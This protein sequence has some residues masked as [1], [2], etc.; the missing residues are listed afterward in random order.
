MPALIQPSFA[1]GEISPHLY[2]RV[3]TAAYYVALALARNVIVHP[4]GGI[5]NRPGT[6]F[7]APCGE[8]TYAPRLIDFQF[9][10]TDTYVLEFGHLY[11]R[12]IRNDG[13]VL[14]A[15]KNITAISAALPGVVTSNAHGFANG[16]EVFLQSIVG[17]T[18]LNGRWFRVANVTANTFTLKDQV[19]GFDISTVG[20][21]AY[22]SGG[23]ASRVY[24]LT[25]PYTSAQIDRLKVVQNAD[26]M[27]I[28]H[29]SHPVN[30]LTRTAHDAWTITP[31]TFGASW[32]LPGGLT[33]TPSPTGAVTYSYT[34]TAI[35]KETGKESL[36]GLISASQ[37]I[38]AA[39]AANP[40][41]FTSA[42]HGNLTGDLVYLDNIA[43]SGPWT[44]LNGRYFTINNA[45]AN[46]YEIIDEDNNL[47]D[48][49]A[50]GAYPG[51]GR[52]RRA[53]VKIT[54]GAATASNTIGWTNINAERYYVYKFDNGQFGFIGETKALSFKDDN[55]QANLARTPPE[56]R[57]FAHEAGKYPQA[58]GYHEQR[59]IF[60][61]SDTA[62]DQ[63]DFSQVGG[64]ENM[65]RS[66]P[67]QAD[68]AFTTK[69]NSRQV[70]E[71]RHFVSLSDL[72]TF[73]DGAEW[74]S[75]A[76]SDS[77]F[78]AESIRQRQQSTWGCSHI[79]PLVVGD[80]VLFI[81]PS[82]SKVR[83]L[84][85]SFQ[86]DGYSG[87]QVNL[88]S[89]HMTEF[90]SF[91]D[92]AL[93]MAPEPR[94]YAP[95][96]DGE[97]L[98][99][100]YEQEQEVIGWSH[101]D[102]D[103][104]YE[105][106]CVLRNSTT[107]ASREN[108]IYYIIKRKINGVTVRYIEKQ[109]SRSI[110]DVRDAYFVD[111]GLSYDAPIAIEG[112]TSANPVVVTATGHGL[113]NGA[114]V[115][116]SGIKWET[117]FDSMFNAV[118]PNHLN[119]VQFLVANATANTFEIT[120]MLGAPIDGSGFSGYIEGGSIR[121]CVSTLTGF[122]HILGKEIVVLADGDVF[123]GITIDTVAGGVGFTLPGGRKAA[124]IHAGLRF[125]SDAQ[126][127]SIESPSG[128]IQGKMA[129]INGVSVRVKDTRGL[130]VGPSFD[131]L[132]PFEDRTDE[133]FGEP[134]RLQNGIRT[135]PLR[136]DWLQ[137]ASACFR[138]AD[139][140]PWTLIQAV[141]DVDVED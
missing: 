126:L 127:L 59:R 4:F 35:D 108:G 62:P 95:A 26:V 17:T 20:L 41:V 107:T 141:L 71:I 89:Q 93:S 74:K 72:L 47:V 30:E 134:T 113:T 116:L 44:V 138:Q 8:H 114:T 87:V 19:T 102:T 68:D 115:E 38:T 112:V 123:T 129:H 125:I 118:D 56:Q 36:R 121:V 18:E 64:P 117:T 14:E 32:A 66:T 16:D 25:T 131:Q 100:T 136:P 6:Y 92:W 48:T 60:G 82:N 31:V 132:E 94:V 9:K 13:H 75:S 106:V 34:I 22:V 101:F 79:R 99:F 39:T 46:T 137:G 105:S 24:T 124:R 42:A 109:A 76:G 98:A 57:F 135:M 55:I 58:P 81:D 5:S 86:K 73:T 3:D 83:T 61:G 91:R 97:C 65:N 110:S 122:D 90:R 133:A 7:I 49:S 63:T 119:N 21:G 27:T 33:C 54:N 140:L 45:A 139:P 12:V 51:S 128:T 96:D 111:C 103:G 69:L 29:P 84:G 11:M 78:S 120:D 1:K 28:T 70:N 50:F 43:G 53:F 23:T 52:T 88:L 10:T 40:G 104:S 130:R 80:T 85:Y 15:A 37:T 2:G 67:L 77:A